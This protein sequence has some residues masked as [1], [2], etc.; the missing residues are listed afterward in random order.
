[1][2]QIDVEQSQIFREVHRVLPV[3]VRNTNQI[4][5][6]AVALQQQQYLARRRTGGIY[7]QLTEDVE[8]GL[9]LD[10]DPPPLLLTS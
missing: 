8:D 1:M 4:G 3:C 10:D 9:L 7:L 5:A 6:P 2:A